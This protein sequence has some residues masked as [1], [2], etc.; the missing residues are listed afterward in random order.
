MFVDLAFDRVHD[1]CNPFSVVG[2][3]KEVGQFL[4]ELVDV[5]EVGDTCDVLSFIRVNFALGHTVK[6]RGV[7]RMDWADVGSCWGNEVVS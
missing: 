6:C 5:F 4:F 3:E 1:Y 7:S 2:R